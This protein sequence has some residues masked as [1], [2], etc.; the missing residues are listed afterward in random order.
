MGVQLS[1]EGHFALLKAGVDRWN[2]FRR[3]YP[4]YIVMNCVSLADAQLNNVDLHCVLL[5]ES[6]LRRANLAGAILERAILRKSDL[7]G[8]DLRNAVLDGAD[9][10]RANFSGADLRGASMAC[11]FLK[12]TDLTGAD[13][14]TARGLT[15]AQINDAYGDERTRLPADLMRPPGWAK[16]A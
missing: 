8:S 7:R 15:P 4:E 6:D 13:L 14:S 12:R 3:E 11:A 2:S 9:L 5:M 1:K 10:C 16:T